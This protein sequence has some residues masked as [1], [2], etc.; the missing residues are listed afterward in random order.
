[1]KSRTGKI[2]IWT[3][4]KSLQNPQKYKHP[5]TW[6]N[7]TFYT[8]RQNIKIKSLANPLNPHTKQKENQ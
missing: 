7:V 4:L 8:Q 3:N 5:I 1:M 6:I 2:L